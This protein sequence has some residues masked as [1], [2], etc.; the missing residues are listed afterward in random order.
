VKFPEPSSST[1]TAPEA[2]L[3]RIK[4]S[5]IEAGHLNIRITSLKDI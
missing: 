5:I 2:A 1:K 4:I 3:A